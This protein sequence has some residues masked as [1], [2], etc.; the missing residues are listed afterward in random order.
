MMRVFETVFDV[1]ADVSAVLAVFWRSGE[2]LTGQLQERA[3][4]LARLCKP[5]PTHDSEK[6]ST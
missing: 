1:A 6:P 4:Q 2:L 5:I 3:P